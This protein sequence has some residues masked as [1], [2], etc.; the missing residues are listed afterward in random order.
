MKNFLKKTLSLILSLALLASLPA[1]AF[2]E[3]ANEDEPLPQEPE[4]LSLEDV[5]GE[6]ITGY[7]QD[8][9]KYV[10]DDWQELAAVY[11]AGKDLPDYVL[12]K[13]PASGASAVLT[14]LMKGDVETAKSAAEGMVHE[15]SLSMFG[16]T[17][18][19]AL[20]ILAMEA[21]NRDNL[22]PLSYDKAA[23]AA[24]LMDNVRE[25]GGFD[26]GTG[27]EGSDAESTAIAL[28]ALSL[29]AADNT[30]EY[31]PAVSAAITAGKSYLHAQQQSNGGF[32]S[33]FSGNNANSAAVVCYAIMALGEDPNGET[34]KNAEGK[35]PLDALLSFKVTG[36][37]FGAA[38]NTSAN[39]MATAQAVLAL[40][41]ILGET[42][43]FTG[44]KLS[45]TNLISASTQ[46]IPENGNF[47]EKN[48]T[49]V[50]GSG[51]AAALNKTLST[52]NSTCDDFL[53]YV[54]GTLC[55]DT[56]NAVLEEGDQ[57]LAVNKAF[58]TVAYFKA[59]DTDTLGSASATIDFGGEKTFTLVQE[60]L[61]QPGTQTPMANIPVDI[62]GDGTGDYTT[63]ENGSVTIAPLEAKAHTVKALAITYDWSGTPTQHIPATTALIPGTL[64]MKTGD[65][66]T[67]TVSLR[68]EGPDGNIYYNEEFLA[69][70]SGTGKLTVYDALTQALDSKNIPYSAAGGFLSSVNNIA[71]GSRGAYKTG[72]HDGAGFGWDGWLFTFE[73]TAY[74]DGTSYINGM[75][76]ELIEENDKILVYYG[77]DDMSTVYPFVEVAL[78]ESGAVTLTVKAY[79]TDYTTYLTTLEPLS[80]VTVSWDEEKETALSPVTD[81]NGQVTIPADKAALGNHTLQL[82]KPDA[83]GLN[84]VVPLAPGWGVTVS[85]EAASFGK[86]IENTEEENPEQGV[87]PEEKDKVFIQVLGPNRQV[88]LGTTSFDYYSGITAMDLLRRTSLNVKLDGSRKYVESI[89]GIGE[90]DTGA[91]SGWLYKVNGNES[92]LDSAADYTLRP[93]DFVVFFFSHD[94][95]E[96]AGSESWSENKK[97]D[98][99][100][101]EKEKEEVL[102]PENIEAFAKM[103]D[104]T[105]ANW[106][107]EAAKYAVERGYFAGT[108]AT[109]FDGDKTM[110]RAMWTTV[111]H[112]VAGKPATKEEASFPDMAAGAYY[113]DAAAWAE[114][115]GIAKGTNGEF[116]PDTNVSR[117]QLVTMLYRYGVGAKLIDPEKKAADL[118]DFHDS[119]VVSDWAKE[120]LTWAV[121]EKILTGRPG[122]LLAPQDNCTRAETAAILQRFQEMVKALE[123]EE[124]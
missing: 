54:N 111:L 1:F 106:Y 74:F 91:N 19:D 96:E 62:N 58:D 105:E 53:C 33:D 35:S 52:E 85:A 37:G 34:W 92:I 17:Y 61:S 25:D 116:R 102:L 5:L 89:N 108:S 40:S 16:Y 115:L 121:S 82:A 110:T 86:L 65:V 13:T 98:K 94:Y 32:L 56:E 26:Y 46:V 42:S 67:C 103:T 9:E 10:L 64:T 66:Q 79:K 15:G 71:G 84:G 70:N 76:A 123:T 95:T 69:G 27:A 30:A 28:I 48:L 90:F 55:E 99:K 122:D 3:T 93:D 114:E 72:V 47:A 107:Y 50:T 120:A 119:E 109:T 31:Y 118:A 112:R 57:L 11:W 73:E 41:E 14:S 97:E 7:Y 60:S 117:E 63:D 83:Y 124:K 75:T 22:L 21:Y 80:D 8:S 24:A 4:T 39:A 43:F 6:A 29:L 104:L 81:E 23:A 51:L 20:S 78:E 68:V 88:F 45:E 2:G 113:A 87:V 44:L 59:N 101:K 77:N 49:L 100:D 38:D 36:S 12:P 18:S